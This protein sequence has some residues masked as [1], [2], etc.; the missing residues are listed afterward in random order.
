MNILYLNHSE[1][2]SGAEN[3]LRALLMQLRRA[4]PELET[5]IALPGAGP[6]SD[7]LRD[8]GW[9]VTFA[10][11]RRVERPRNLVSGMAALVHVL[12]TAPF[13]T[14]LVKETR[15]DIIH[16]N[17]TTAH[18]VGGLAAERT[19]VPAIWHARDLVSLQRIA[20][21]LALRA[22]LVIAISGCV[23]ERLQQDG[24]PPEKIRIIHNGLDPDEWNVRPHNPLRDSFALPS[25]AFVF[26]C[27]GQL[28]PW[29]NQ[30]A[31][32]EAAARLIDDEN[33]SNAH[34]VIMGGNLWNEHGDYVSKLRDMVRSLGLKDR[35]TFIPHQSDNVTGISALDALV[36]PS[37]DEPFGRVL[38]E[39]M[40]LK[41][42]VIAYAENGPIG[43]VTHEHDG[44]LIPPTEADGLA[45]GM[46][47]VLLDREL[48]EVLRHN[49]RETVLQR[50]H[51]A[52]SASK[53]HDIYREL[54]N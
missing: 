28:V 46:R 12:R 22:S 36:L 45:N 38:I 39:G 43:I 9:N 41:R 2:M 25:D 47:R 40:A 8:E 42:V 6:F 30:I 16:S 27:V 44:L 13:L 15:C 32:I 33:C 1:Q 35:F 49:A 50:F 54:A 18:L 31:F 48:C 3:S 23:A 53:I 20:P 37:H 19:N 21:A 7:L 34:F 24:V 14:H 10:P 52:D 4:Y 26:G 29:K 11:M 5:A 51:I 17:S